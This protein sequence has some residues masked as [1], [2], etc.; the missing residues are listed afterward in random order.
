MDA[1]FLVAARFALFADLGLLFGLVLF[2]LYGLRGGERQLLPVRAAILLTGSAGLLASA[3][4]F[5][6]I[7]AAMAGTTLL[8][9]P[10]G[11]LAPLLC[12]TAMGWAVQARIAAL[13]LAMV[14]SA[15]IPRRPIAALAIIAAG[16]GVAL[17]TLAWSGHGAADGVVH[18]AADIVH[19][20]AAGAWLGAI[21][22]FLMLGR[23]AR[24]IASDTVVRVLHRALDSF[25]IMGSAL[26]GLIVATGLVNFYFLVG[27]GQV[28]SLGTSLYGRL[29]LAKIAAFLAMLAIAAINRYRL[30]P[31]LANAI[32]LGDFRAAISAL[33]RSLAFEAGAALV[34]LGIVA[35]LGTL[36]PPIAAG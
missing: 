26:V 4:G 7:T 21:V 34:I 17:A 29:L 16:A 36:E 12:G 6:A 15:A 10:W 30:T 3:F 27:P 18:R 13:L 2:G 31:G 8:G 1:W 9:V 14:A 22:A 23:R 5:I 20:L 35:W 24:A 19:L 33:R 11:M 32:A 28:A 25:S